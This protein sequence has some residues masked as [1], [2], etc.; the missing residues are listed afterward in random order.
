VLAQMR[1]EVGAA[2]EW[3]S[4]TITYATEYGFP[5]W[6][7]LCSMIQGWLMSEHGQTK[8]GID[9][10]QKGLDRYRATGARLGLSWFLALLAEM[11]GKTGAVEEGLQALR[12]ALAHM[13]E[14][15]ER[16]YEAEVLRLNGDLLLQRDQSDVSSAEG[17]FRQAIEVARR[18]SARSWELRAATSLARLWA[19]QNKIVEARDLLAA[20]YGWF[21][22]G[23]DTPDL[24]DAKRLLDEL[25]S[26]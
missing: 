24:R 16:Y 17:C 15:D 23:F 3:A 19:T 7:S 8:E 14:T 2:G 20:V 21:S 10:L 18:Q 22:E 12:Q 1:R 4:K 11:H 26:A 25:S 9:H 6:Y 5:Y 13:Q